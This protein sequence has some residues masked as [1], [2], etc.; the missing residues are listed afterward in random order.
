MNCERTSCTNEAAG[1]LRMEFFPHQIYQREDAA[2][3]PIPLQRM[4]LGLYLCP[5]CF[6]LTRVSDVI[7]GPTLEML[8]QHAMQANAG[9]V[10]DRSRTL[11]TLIPL[12]DPELLLLQRTRDATQPDKESP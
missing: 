8:Y 2:G 1:A 9:L 5:A 4:V 11:L 3:Q 7:H 12:T 6:R 10:P